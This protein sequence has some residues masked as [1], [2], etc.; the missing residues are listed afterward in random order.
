MPCGDVS[1]YI[2]ITVDQNDRLKSYRLTKGTCGRGVGLDYLLQERLRGRSVEELLAGEV[3][4]LLDEDAT[5]EELLEFLGLKHLLAIR[6][7]LQVYSGRA[8]GG[9]A[10]ACTVSGISYDSSESSID[11][12]INVDLLTSEI[13]PCGGCGGG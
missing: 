11:A 5:G 10:A 7:T 13:E 2:S 6:A 1:E 3:E 4:E 9:L 12:I 8:S